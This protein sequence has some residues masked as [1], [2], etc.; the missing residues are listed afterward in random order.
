MLPL[1]E[2]LYSTSNYYEYINLRNQIGDV[3]NGHSLSGT[4]PASWAHGVWCPFLFWTVPDQKRINRGLRL[5][6]L[7]II[8]AAMWVPAVIV[9]SRLML[10]LAVAIPLLAFVSRR[11]NLRHVVRHWAGAWRPLLGAL[12]LTVAGAYVFQYFYHGTFLESLVDLGARALGAPAAV[13][14]CYYYAFPEYFP[15][16]GWLG[17]LKFP[18]VGDS[19]DFHLVSLAAT[20]L[21]SNANGSF[22]ATAYSGAGFAGVAVAAAVVFVFA[23]WLD[24]KLRRVPRRLANAVGFSNVIPA[25]VLG[26]APALTAMA[27]FGFLLGPLV[28]VVLLTMFRDIPPW[29]PAETPRNPPLSS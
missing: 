28:I 6:W 19:V 22:A 24:G 16:R 7:G 1:V 23:T 14:G 27:T 15:F 13:S 12:G 17:I 18:M 4:A 9:G 21:D 29:R 2:R 20:G 5:V 3:I 11:F 25:S 10:L 8:A 26:S